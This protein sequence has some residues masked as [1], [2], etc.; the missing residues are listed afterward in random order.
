MQL[1][2][3]LLLVAVILVLFFQSNR[4]KGISQPAEVHATVASNLNL[5]YLSRGKLF[6][7]PAGAAAEQVHSQYVQQM[8]DRAEKAKQLHGWKEDT[9]WGTSFVGKGVQDNDGDA[10]GVD[11]AASAFVP[12]ENKLL[13]FLK[14]K[15][16]GG[17][18]EYDVATGNELRLVHKQNLSFEDMQYNRARDQVLCATHHAN[19]I[20]NIVRMNRDGGDFTELT[21]GDSCDTS[22]CW[23]DE[24][25]VVYQSQGHARG[26]EGYIVAY[27]PSS[28]QLLDLETS[29]VSP[30]LEDE[31]TDYLQPRVGSSGDLYYLRRPHQAP[32]YGS[33][34]ALV[35]TLLFPF[36]LLRAVFHYLNFF[37]LMY[38]RKPLTS[39][40]G[41]QVQM[42]TK[43]LMLKGMRINAEKALKTEKQVNGVPSL[44]PASW[45]LV[46]R[47]R[48]GAESVL[49][50]HVASFTLGEG[51][52]VV[53]TNGCGIFLLT[54]QGAATIARDRVIE[55]LIV[56]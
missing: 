2:L 27:A 46:R 11:F 1:L 55:D 16:F 36:R 20:A 28:I 26:A 56:W 30:V 3:L 47:D 51:D 5:A 17:L 45:Q 37:S 41:P 6:L 24:N 48:T 50:S 40:S 21:G 15:S 31:S 13:Y 34:N 49:A 19:G 39:A 44:V 53:Y 10:L 4:D 54:P 7:K 42:D 33:S 43:E 32:H 8:A 22:P 25:K 9:S 12:G 23:V 38:A 52:C 18:F 35:D 14:D 29:G